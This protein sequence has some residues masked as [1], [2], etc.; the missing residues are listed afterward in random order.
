[1][2]KFFCFFAFILMLSC[3]S[4]EN[5][6]VIEGQLTD[7]SYDGE[8]MYLVPIEGA[9]A[10]TV[11]S[12]LIK[13]GAFRFEGDASES[14]I[15]ILRTRP[16]LRLELQELL[17]V[18]EPGQIDVVIDSISV[19][20]GTPQND[21]LQKWKERKKNADFTYAYLN[22]QISEADENKKAKLKLLQGKFD[23]EYSDF[24]YNFV[25]ENKNTAVG[26]F[27]Y[28]MTGFSFTPEQKKEIDSL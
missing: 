22:Q 20:K 5:N 17:V 18:T 16:L 4:V 7:K 1:M 19:A 6:Y 2:Q 27:V 14:A 28:K 8:Y 21:A 15:H 9:T 12:V 13:D 10:E 25:K 23:K 24:N 26:K 3:S 11:D